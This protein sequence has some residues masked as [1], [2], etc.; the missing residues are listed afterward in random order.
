MTGLRG[1]KADPPASLAVPVSSIVSDQGGQTFRIGYVQ[2]LQENNV[3]IS[4]ITQADE[5]GCAP[6]AKLVAKRLLGVILKNDHGCL[7]L[8]QCRGSGQK[9]VVA[10]PSRGG[11]LEHLAHLVVPGLDYQCGLVRVV[12]RARRGRTG[13]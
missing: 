4:E 3:F 8:G 12:K 6:V 11:R 5:P 13:G 2:A 9:L 10:L 1:W 7:M